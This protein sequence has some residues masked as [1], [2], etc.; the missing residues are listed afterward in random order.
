MSTKVQTT[1]LVLEDAP[2][3]PPLT[4]A[5]GAAAMRRYAQFKEQ[6]KKR[7]VQDESEGQDEEEQ[8]EESQEEAREEAMPS[9]P[10]PQASKV[11]R[12]RKKSSPHAVS[13]AALA[14]AWAKFSKVCRF[15]YGFATQTVAAEDVDL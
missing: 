10:Q 14:P 1:V 3:N 7:H 6:Q 15:Q 11:A 4:A 12:K 5:A 9:E 13:S 8:D 2:W